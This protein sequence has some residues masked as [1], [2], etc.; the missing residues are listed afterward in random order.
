MEV[1]IR[2]RLPIMPV[3]PVILVRMALY[4]EVLVRQTVETPL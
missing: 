2:F 4:L 1:V 3:M